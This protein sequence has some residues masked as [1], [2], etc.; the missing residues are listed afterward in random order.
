MSQN[1]IKEIPRNSEQ[2]EAK[3]R[4]NPSFEKKMLQF[5]ACRYFPHIAKKLVWFY[6]E[7]FDNEKDTGS[8]SATEYNWESNIPFF[9]TLR[10]EGLKTADGSVFSFIHLDGA[11]FPYT[12]NEEN[13]ASSEQTDAIT[14]AKSSLNLV[15]EY[16]KNLKKLNLYENSLIVVTSDHGYTSDVRTSPVLLIKR[17]QEHGTMKISDAPVS[18]EDLLGT[19]A[20]ELNLSSDY[21]VSMY[22]VKENDRRLRRYMSYSAEDDSLSSGYLPDLMEYMVLPEGNDQDQFIFTGK[23]YTKNGLIE[24][25]AYR[26][27]P[28]TK[29]VFT[30][31]NDGRS[32]FLCGISN[33]E[34]DYAWSCGEKS[35]IMLKI[36]TEK[37]L[38]AEIAL[39]SVYHDRQ[40]VI[41]SDGNDTVLFDGTADRTGLTFSIPKESLSDGTLLLKFVYPEA[42]SPQENGES[43]DTRVLAIAFTS[44]LISE[45]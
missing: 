25:E 35:G 26:Y 20:K 19:I 36:D 30:E 28:G 33:I 29:I 17:F 31:E 10:T 32:Y 21:G 15:F 42:S 14:E 18:H 24:T 4:S 22:E 11:H 2:G 3:V 9:N 43:M 16:L 8:M 6:G 1:F 39:S 23:N 40:R 27:S 37:D 38:F 45:Q 5:T 13:V 7:E 44:I 34:G 12:R 41:I